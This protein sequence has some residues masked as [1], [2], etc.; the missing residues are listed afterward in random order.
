MFACLSV[1]V[2]VNMGSTVLSDPGSQ[3]RC[4]YHQWWSYHPE[5]DAGSSSCCQN[6]QSYCLSFRLFLFFH[7][8]HCP[9]DTYM[10]THSAEVMHSCQLAL[11]FL[12]LQT[13][14]MVTEQASILTSGFIP[15]VLWTCAHIALAKQKELIM[16]EWCSYKVINCKVQ[17]LKKERNTSLNSLS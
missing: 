10:H 17:N 15:V 3:W 1:R 6:G 14:E 2:W 11:K 4:D 13:M 7:L 8:S 12:S 16:P 9:Q 5:T